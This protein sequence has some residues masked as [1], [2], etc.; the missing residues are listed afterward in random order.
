MSGYCVYVYVY[1]GVSVS[2]SIQ[3]KIRILDILER[4]C[5]Y[6]DGNAVAEIIKRRL[7]L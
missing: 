2:V 5:I 7:H 1:V 6:C 4:F 3:R